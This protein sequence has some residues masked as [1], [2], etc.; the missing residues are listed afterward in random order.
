MVESLIAWKSRRCA[1]PSATI[2]T[3][4]WQP[5]RRCASVFHSSRNG[6]RRCPVNQVLVAL[7]QSSRRRI[8]RP[9]LPRFAALARL[10]ASS[11]PPRTPSRCPR[12]VRL[13]SPLL[14]QVVAAGTSRALRA[15]FRSSTMTDPLVL[16]PA[17]RLNRQ[18]VRSASPD[19]PRP[20]LALESRSFAGVM[21]ARIARRCAFRRTPRV[22]V[23]ASLRSTMSGASSRRLHGK[24][25]A[26]HKAIQGRILC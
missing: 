1:S 26:C 20:I 4:D 6:G 10:A 2:H 15:A 7:D 25:A 18:P 17:A 8:H 23:I 16:R 22:E 3:F 13:R 12:S 5:C 24:S 14:A 19:S 21:L 11:P 9:S